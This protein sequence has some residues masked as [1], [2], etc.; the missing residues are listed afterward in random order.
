MAL[1]L[2]MT[3]GGTLLTVHRYRTEVP[4]GFQ[5]ISFTRDISRKG[6]GFAERDGVPSAVIPQDV[7]AL[8]GKKIYVKGFMYPG[9]RENYITQFV[10]CKDN[11]QCCFGGEPALQ[12]MIGIQLQDDNTTDFTPTLVGVAGTLELN[13]NYQGGKVEPLYLLKAEQVAEALTSL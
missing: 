10:L 5:R 1:G 4:A 9:S 3:V 12:D 6:I 8:V 7:M 11:G 2:V 13:E